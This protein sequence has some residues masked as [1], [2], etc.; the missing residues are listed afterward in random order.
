[1]LGRGVGARVRA[2]A[3]SLPFHDGSFD[4]AVGAF[5][6]H[7]LPDPVA[8]LREA[9]RCVRRAGR[10]VLAYGG[11]FASPEWDFWFEV[12]ARHA[13]RGTLE[14]TLP[15]PT[16]IPDA[17]AAFC[18][19]GM[20]DVRVAEIEIA[21]PVDDP[22]S[23]LLGEQAHGARSFFDR[24]DADVRREVEA[25]LLEH[26]AVMHRDGGIMLRRAALFVE[27]RTP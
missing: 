7:L 5:S 17:E 26:L 13:D 4:V 15:S 8:G 12:L 9:A 23:F 27:G 3:R 24:F 25:E 2:D 21:V 10:V 6:I 22:R 19:A 18:E 1:M 16:P 11:R 20:V 14:P